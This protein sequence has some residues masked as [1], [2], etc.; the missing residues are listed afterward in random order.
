MYLAIHNTKNIYTHTELILSVAK[1]LNAPNPLLSIHRPT[2]SMLDLFV[3][4]GRA[5]VHHVCVGISQMTKCMGARPFVAVAEYWL[6]GWDMSF[7]K[8]PLGEKRFGCETLLCVLFHGI[9]T[10]QRDQGMQCHRKERGLR[11]G[12]LLCAGG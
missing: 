8:I 5:Q 7:V 9:A 6:V 12:V 11:R 2:P 1:S 3:K 4:G 10:A